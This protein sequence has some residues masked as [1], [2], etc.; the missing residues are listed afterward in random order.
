M[1]FRTWAILS[2][3]WVALWAFV[4]NAQP[5]SGLDPQLVAG[6]YFW[7]PVILGALCLCAKFLGGRRGY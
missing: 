7:P 6:A 2:V 3:G 4:N 1:L 5:N